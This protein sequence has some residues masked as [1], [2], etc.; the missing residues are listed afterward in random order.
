MGRSTIE[1]TNPTIHQPL[2]PSTPEKRP[3][4]PR[5]NIIIHGR[6][7]Y[8]TTKRISICDEILSQDLHLGIKEIIGC[9]EEG[10]YIYIKGEG[11]V[12]SVT[13]SVTLS[14]FHACDLQTAGRRKVSLRG[15]GGGEV[16][17]YGGTCDNAAR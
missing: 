6:A 7:S 4:V 9:D 14:T 16:P 8:Y 1:Y 13:I 5:V 3:C 17:V 2:P 12:E 11:K 10:M 15:E